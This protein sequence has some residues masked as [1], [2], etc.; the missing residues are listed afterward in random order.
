VVIDFSAYAGQRVE[1]RNLG[2][3]NSVDFDNTDKV[4]AF[5]V[6]GNA[7]DTTNG[8]EPQPLPDARIPAVMRLTAA[9]ATKRRHLRFERQGSEWTINGKTWEDVEESGLQ[10]TIADP[11]LDAVELWELENR[12]GGWFHPIHIHLVDFRILDRNGRPPQPYEKGP[13][14]VVYLGEGET[15]RL[16]ARFGPH[17]G[18]YML[19]CHNNSHEDHDMMNQMQIGDDGPDPVTTAPPQGG[20][21]P[22]YTVVT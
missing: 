14:D 7:T 19:H 20:T 9:D 10:D 1:L 15:V 11:E 2:T 13:K 8:G 21:P 5:D 18:R 3:P 17:N 12:S 22:A 16:V 6:V 4:M